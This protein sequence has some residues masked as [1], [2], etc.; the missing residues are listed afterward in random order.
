MKETRFK[1]TEDYFFGAASVEAVFVSAVVVVVV[2]LASVTFV[3]DALEQH[4]AFADDVFVHAS[5]EALEHASFEAALVALAPSH[6]LAGAIAMP[7]HKIAAAKN[8]TAFIDNSFNI[9]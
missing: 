8:F 6:A 1:F 2:V 5:A 3:E 4:D 9:R 7:R